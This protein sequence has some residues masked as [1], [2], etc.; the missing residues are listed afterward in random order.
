MIHPRI[1]DDGCFISASRGHIDVGGKR[2]LL[3]T[4]QYKYNIEYIKCRI[5]DTNNKQELE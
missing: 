1:V 5:Y 4:K 3:L 2:S